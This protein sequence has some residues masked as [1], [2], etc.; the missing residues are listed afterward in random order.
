VLHANTKGGRGTAMHRRWSVLAAANVAVWLGAA[1]CLGPVDRV[2]DDGGAVDAAGAIDA[3]EPDTSGGGADAGGGDGSVYEAGSDVA[4]QETSTPP[5]ASP[6]AAP[7]Q[8]YSCN[9]QMVTSCASCG[10]DTTEC[11]FCAQDGGHP[12]VCGPKGTYCQMSAPA[13][14]AICTCQGLKLGSCVAPFQVCVMYGPS[15]YC[16]TCGE[17]GSEGYACKDGGTCNAASG[18]CK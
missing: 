5:E 18:T 3:W 6:E 4:T 8:Q 11:V 13:N 9:G 1:A 16:Q 10:S 2:Y 14:A 7:G 12:G 15:D 17:M